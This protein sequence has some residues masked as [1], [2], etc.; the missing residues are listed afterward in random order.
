[1]EAIKTTSKQKNILFVDSDKILQHDLEDYLERKEVGGKYGLEFS[2]AENAKEALKKIADH[3]IDLVVLEILLPVINGYYLINA[4][5]KEKIPVIIYT[6]IKSG[7]DL[8]KLAAA[9]VD[10]IFL[11]ELVKLE[12]L[13]SILANEDSHKAELDH[14]VPELQNQIKT[15]MGG[16]EGEWGHLKTVQCPRCNV[17][18]APD[19]YFCNNC[20]QKIFKKREEIKLK[21]KE[22]KQK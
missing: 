7:Q 8:S 12:D 17:V 5:K 9:E 11:K 6:K 16:E 22:N 14:L 13:V 1:M 2:F 3:K 20:G 4:L 10:N 19:S 15:L 18:L 21:N